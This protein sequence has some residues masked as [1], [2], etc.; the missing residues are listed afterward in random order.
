MKSLYENLKN[1]NFRAAFLEECI[2][3][4]HKQSEL[5]EKSDIRNL[6]YLDQS[7]LIAAVITPNDCSQYDYNF[8]DYIYKGIDTEVLIPFLNMLYKAFVQK[9]CEP[10]IGEDAILEEITLPDLIDEFQKAMADVIADDVRNEFH[11]RNRNCDLS[12]SEYELELYENEI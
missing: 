4:M 11:E 5:C 10:P 2:D 6:D 12:K 9:R 1:D 3:K 7:N 8:T